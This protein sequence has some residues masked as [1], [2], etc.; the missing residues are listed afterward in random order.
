MRTR[1]II[2]G[3]V[4]WLGLALL[5]AIAIR[6]PFAQQRQTLVDV[7]VGTLQWVMGAPEELEA[8]S[9]VP[10]LIAPGDPVFLRLPDG[11]YRQVGRVRDHFGADMF[12]S[13]SRRAR[14]VLYDNTVRSAFPEGFVLEY[15]TTPTALDWVAR[16]MITPEKQKE[17]A[18]IMADDWKQHRE[19]IIRR[20]QP[21]FET[22]LI[23][24][25][26]AIEAEL[27]A[28]MSEHRSD[29]ATLAER[30]QAEMIRKSFVPLVREQILPIVQEEVRPLAMDLGRDLWDR[31]SLWS[32]TWRY[33]YDVSP[34]PERNA[35]KL[36]FDRFI[37]Q[38]VTPALATR[39]EEFVTVTERI[40]RRISRNDK[41]RS[42]VRENLRKVAT[43]AQFQKI[44]WDVVQE[45]FIN[46]QTLRASLQ[47]YWASPEVRDALDVASSRFEPTAREIGN[48][49]FGSREGGITPEFSSVLRVQILMK[50]RRWFVVAPGSNDRG[51]Q[52]GPEPD[53]LMMQ[54]AYKSMPY[55]LSFEGTGQSPLTELAGDGLNTPETP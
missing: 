7:L 50:D 2:L 39:S 45:A 27:P 12:P 49:L 21:V 30:Y 1:Q 23:K 20:L 55:P 18:G 46:N 8:E 47:D 14:I 41:V 48:T 5:L 13:W 44:I 34:L 43:D 37:E 17:I 35:V 42:V 24:A 28:V 32:F 19:E 52:M 25:F 22:S 40:V 4:T 15:H 29:F 33:L 10:L 36:E 9:A 54:P 3:T 16:T 26:S 38:E 51:K 53:N 31:V 11:D 6:R